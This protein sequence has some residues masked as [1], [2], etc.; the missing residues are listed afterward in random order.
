MNHFANRK[1]LIERE[2]IAY[3]PSSRFLSDSDKAS[4]GNASAVVIETK[5][6]GNSPILP[7]SRPCKSIMSASET[8]DDQL[9][10]LE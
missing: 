8:A 4:P 6:E 7:R 2:R 3:F 9:S 5:L 10:P 1:Q